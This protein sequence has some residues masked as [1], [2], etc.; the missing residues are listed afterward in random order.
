MFPKYPHVT[1]EVPVNNIPI[2]AS[3]TSTVYSGA[4]EQIASVSPSTS[5]GSPCWPVQSAGRSP[6]I[7]GPVPRSR[8]RRPWRFDHDQVP[9]TT[10]DVTFVNIAATTGFQRHHTDPSSSYSTAPNRIGHR[11]H[12]PTFPASERRELATLRPTTTAR[13]NRAL[14]NLGDLHLRRIQHRHGLCCLR[15]VNIGSSL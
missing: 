13:C 3:F 6:P 9:A 8:S 10:F 7:T 15:H 1:V 11:Q 2:I 5:Q 12:Q 4:L 14:A